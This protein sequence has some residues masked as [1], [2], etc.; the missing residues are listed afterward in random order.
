M[1]TDL[2]AELHDLMK[3][4]TSELTT[5][6]PPVKSTDGAKVY[7][8]GADKPQFGNLDWGTL[9]FKSPPEN[10]V[11][12][13]I[14]HHH[15]KSDGWERNLSLPCPNPKITE[16][17]RKAIFLIILSDH[18]ATTAGRAL[19]KRI[20]GAERMTVHR[21]WNP[22]FAQL[23]HGDP[24][25]IKDANSLTDALNL[26]Q[27]NDAKK[28][29]ETF[30][31]NMEVKPEDETIPRNVTSLLSH[32]QLV[33]QFY[34]I[35]KKNITVKHEPLWL[36]LGG[37]SVQTTQDAEQRWSLHSLRATVKFHQNP[38]RPAD[39]NLFGK[40]AKVS[41][42]LEN[43]FGDELLFQTSD[44]VWLVLPYVAEDAEPAGL[45]KKLRDAFE[46]VLNEHLYLEIEIKTAPLKQ[47][48][49]WLPTAVQQGLTRRFQVG[50]KPELVQVQSQISDQEQAVKRLDEARLTLRRQ[51][52]QAMDRVEHGK[53]ISVADREWSDAKKKL[54]NLQNT[55]T[56]LVQRVAT[57]SSS[58]SVEQF[59]GEYAHISLYPKDIAECSAF[60]PPICEICQMRQAKERPMANTIDYVC[61]V[62]EEI[63]TGGLYQGSIDDWDLALWV[64][65]NLEAHALESALLNLYAD[66]VEANI[67]DVKIREECLKDVR[68]AAVARDFVEDYRAFLTDWNARLNEIAPRSRDGKPELRDL[69]MSDLRL[70]QLRDG[71]QLYHLLESFRVLCRSRFP[72][73][74]EKDTMPP[75]RLGISI[76]DPKYP[77]FQHWRYI[78][79]PPQPISVRVVG[80]RPME[81]GLRAFDL[82]VG[83][84]L[85][86]RDREVKRGRTYLHKLAQIEQRS[87]STALATLTLLSDRHDRRKLSPRVID[88]FADAI[89]QGV[90]RMRDL[91]AYEHLTTFGLE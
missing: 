3:L 79:K 43:Q 57:Q 61:D 44:S 74:F 10:L 65:V 83:L 60:P 53:R 72:V 28:L 71:A 41:E 54:V 66:Y 2:I 36:S 32:S 56:A 46:P 62:C 80:K 35:L 38:V 64:K 14:T 55:E 22:R 48:G 27:S 25:P 42:Q 17:D 9:G 84:D 39:L 23:M 90:L 5:A 29:W 52:A 51:S 78:S 26:I 82:L 34:R 75:I 37:E 1:A 6:T 58:D 8:H 24:E 77:F 76:S 63:R 91:L 69:G 70:I 19:G 12:W 68:I 59:A 86:D 40:L 67:V 88:S 47:V 13:A 7:V 20:G 85:N 4:A 87:A 33:G 45:N 18:L 16:E 21:L 11:W 73:W 49:V 31:P 50:L 89:E 15:A 81:I 30:R